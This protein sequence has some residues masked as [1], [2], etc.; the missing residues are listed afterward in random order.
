MVG[1]NFPITSWEKAIWRLGETYYVREA[2]QIVDWVSEATY[3]F[4]LGKN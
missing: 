2:P 4:G 3:I 1:V